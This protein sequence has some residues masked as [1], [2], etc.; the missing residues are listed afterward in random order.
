LKISANSQ[1][2]RTLADIA[3]KRDGMSFLTKLNDLAA[4]VERLES[5]RRR[6]TRGRTNQ[7]GAAQ[8][9][10][11]SREY[12]RTLH[13]RG[14][15]PRRAADGSYNFDDLDDFAERSRENQRGSSSS[16]EAGARRRDP[17]QLDT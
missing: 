6:T 10:G 7:R 13:L 12:L 15:G 2:G 17:Q 8:Y 5:D 16:P 9:L 3:E 14:E 4:R 1:H 11:R